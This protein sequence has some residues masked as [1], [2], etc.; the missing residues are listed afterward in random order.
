MDSRNISVESLNDTRNI[1]HYQK[2]QN[3]TDFSRAKHNASNPD[4]LVTTF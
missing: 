1:L 4:K 3:I 2:I